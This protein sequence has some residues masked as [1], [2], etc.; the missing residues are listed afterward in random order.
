ME[1]HDPSGIKEMLR[2]TDPY[3]RRDACSAAAQRSVAAL[4]PDL[5]SALSD[6]DLGVKEAALNS[7]ITIGG[8]EVAEALVPLLRSDDASLRNMAIEIL[9]HTGP[10]TAK[11]ISRLLKD[12]DEDV[13]KFAVDIIAGLKDAGFVEEVGPLIKHRNANIRASAAL[14]LGRIKGKGALDLLLGALNDREDWVRFSVIEGIGL[15]EDRAA[16]SHLIQIIESDS[17]LIKEA[18]LEAVGKLAAP[19]DAVGALLK[20]EAILKKGQI[21]SYEAVLELFEKAM[22]PSVHFSPSREFKEIFFWFFSKG[23]EENSRSTAM[24]ALK[25]LS[26]LEMKEGFQKVFRLMD[27]LKEINE[28]E[29]AS[30]VDAIASLSG[31]GPLPAVLVEEVRK[32]ARHR[33]VLL[34]VIGKIKSVDAVPLLESLIESAS[35]EDSR[36]IVSAL[37]AIGSPAS[38]DALLRL[39]K[40]R[41]GHTRKTAA[42]ALSRLAGSEA[43]APLLE[44]LRAEVYR[45]VMEEITDSLSHIPTDYVKRTLCALLSEPKESLREMALRALGRLGDEE[46][47]PCIKKALGDASA[48][49]RKAAYKTLAKLGIPDSTDDLL[50][51]L[52]DKDPEVRLSVIKSLSG[53]SGE[54]IER[55]LIE[56]LRD[57]N[58]WIRYHSVLLLGETSGHAA[59]DAVVS[60][61]ETDEPPVRAAAAKAL[62][63]LGTGKALASLMRLKDHHDA[64]VKSA[65][66]KAIE[67]L[68]CSHSE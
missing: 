1:A 47:L 37:E 2:S 4:I 23:L 5:V 9:S 16:L 48:A 38:L 7:L 33:K 8:E 46:A 14:C 67:T 30:F 20:T 34:T 21:L 64:A 54:G 56:A 6:K 3:V 51:G 28:D 42:R 35:K 26:L 50:T 40:N 17:G 18:A 41:D 22:A 68:S 36:D 53:W 60:I 13:I 63:R 12:K 62:E 27:S 61:L 55:A 52:K 45:D 29:E 39:L 59:E 65:V 31:P 25:G 44:A 19:E 43:A 32:G 49:V 11:V 66:E 57:N 24:K 15:L 10:Q 58:M